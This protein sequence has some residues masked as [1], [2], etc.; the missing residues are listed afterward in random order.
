MSIQDAVNDVL[1]LP[2][3]TKVDWDNV[4]IRHGV[5]TDE[6]VQELN[7]DEVQEKLRSE[8]CLT[9]DIHTL[10]N[11]FYGRTEECEQITLNLSSFVPN[12]PSDKLFS[13]DKE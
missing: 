9:K 13:K 4:C 1:S 12:R 10:I 8:L 6:L 11:M 2:F 3:L 5:K 7:K